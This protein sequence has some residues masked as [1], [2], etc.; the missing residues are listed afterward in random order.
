VIAKKHFFGKKKQISKQFP[1]TISQG[2]LGEVTINNIEF[3]PDKTLI[4]FNFIGKNA[5]DVPKR[6]K[7]EGKAKGDKLN[8]RILGLAEG[9]YKM[10]DVVK[11]GKNSYIQEYEAIENIGKLYVTTTAEVDAQPVDELTLDIPLK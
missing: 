3:L 11:T 5:N 8:T 10:K 1:I 4:H 6:I 7:I 2:K 9:K